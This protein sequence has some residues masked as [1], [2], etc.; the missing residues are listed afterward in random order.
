MA[1]GATA[2]GP[3]YAAFVSPMASHQCL[4]MGSLTGSLPLPAMAAARPSYA[5][6]RSYSSSPASPTCGMSR[7]WGMSRT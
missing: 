2:S 6:S 1:G 4:I 3:V 5:L 7:T